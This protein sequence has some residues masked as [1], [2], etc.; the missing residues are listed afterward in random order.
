MMRKRLLTI[1]IGLIGLM[2]PL[3]GIA[4]SYL[5][6]EQVLQE[7]NE[8]FI[9]PGRHRGARWI[10]D[11]EAQMSRDRHPSII[12]EPWDPVVDNGLPPPVVQEDAMPVAEA[13]TQNPYY[14]LDP[15]TAR[16]LARLEQ[17]NM[18]L[19]SQ[20]AGN[21]PLA[22]TGPAAVLSVMAVLAAVGLTLRRARSMERLVRGF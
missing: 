21:A 5:T 4:Q 20:I 22:Q 12:K 8:A 17:Q 18:L 13:P 7:G 16:L 6:P 3:A 2:A 14:G 1:A 19:Q 10:A 11:L 15:V 9:V